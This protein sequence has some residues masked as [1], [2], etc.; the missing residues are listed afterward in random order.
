MVDARIEANW[1]VL[2]EDLDALGPA[3]KAMDCG[4]VDVLI[5]QY[6]ERRIRYVHEEIDRRIGPEQVPEGL[7]VP[8]LLD[9]FIEEV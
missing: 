4:V 5:L 6:Q 8:A 2:L 9:S 7:R 1:T 3:Q